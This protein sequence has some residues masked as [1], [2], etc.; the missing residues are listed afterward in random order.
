MGFLWED[1]IG[2]TYE[3]AAC[4]DRAMDA[5]LDD[6]ALLRRA[7]KH[8]VRHQE[9][10]KALAVVDALLPVTEDPQE[11]ADLWVAQGTVF[12]QGDED[13]ERATEA[14]DMALS[15]MP[16]Y[17][18]ALMGLADVLEKKQDWAQ[19]LQILEASLELQP[20]EE[21]AASL[22]RMATLYQERLQDPQS[23]EKFLRKSVEMEPT[24]EAL[25]TLRGIYEQAPAQ[26]PEAY[27]EVL[28]GLVRFGPPYLELASQVGDMAFELG[29]ERWGWALHAPWANVRSAGSD[30]KSRLRDLRKT[31]DKAELPVI[32]DEDYQTAVRHRQVLAP[33]NEA[34]AAA[35]A[36]IGRLGL[37]DK[38]AAN[39][40]AAYKLS[41]NA[42]LGKTCHQ[43]T[44]AL[45]LPESQTFRADGI[46]QS[47]LVIND[48][49]HPLVMYLTEF[50][51]Q[52]V[53]AESSFLF[54]YTLEWI[55][56]GQVVLAAC[57]PQTREDLVGA[58]LA[59][60]GLREPG[61]GGAAQLAERLQEAVDEPTRTAWGEGLAD[62]AGRDPAEIL[63]RHM[64][65]I[66]F[67]ARRVGLLMAGDLLSAMR[68]W[69]R[70]TEAY[71]NPQG[72]ELTDLDEIID[73]SPELKDLVAFAAS[74]P[75][76]RLLSEG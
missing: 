62:L 5:G 40:D 26:N 71:D 44:Q 65:G 58:V 34:L 12:T 72:K 45:G 43:V 6:P 29:R 76:G 30:I 16:G 10:D 41:P 20:P 70:V 51:R 35:D 22:R 24:K 38:D 31:Y 42:G 25:Q 64:E 23:A 2:N 15:Y 54:G 75:F 74:E 69:G 37:N 66:E 4:Y 27:L 7:L 8:L 9:R 19:L 61:E 53:R 56:P 11:M 47:W 17:G 3:G 18:P 68:A 48:D 46:A 32:P 55:R 39:A 52:F 1:A 59:A 36:A 73:A 67:T 28:S 21:Q 50:L 33:L 49:E 13:L 60:A 63:G 14:F 57:D